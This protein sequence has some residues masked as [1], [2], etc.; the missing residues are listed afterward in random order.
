MSGVFLASWQ[1]PR[2]T[3]GRDGEVCRDLLRHRMGSHQQFEWTPSS[4]CLGQRVVVNRDRWLW[5]SFDGQLHNR[6]VMVERLRLNHGISDAELVAALYLRYDSEFAAFLEG[7]FALALGDFPRGRVILARDVM[8]VCPLH[9]CILPQGVVVSSLKKAVL[10]GRGDAPGPSLLIQSN[11]LH[12]DD[13]IGSDLWREVTSLNPGQQLDYDSR[14]CRRWRFWDFRVDQVGLRPDHGAYVEEFRDQLWRAVKRRALESTSILVSGGVDSS[15]IWSAVQAQHLTD[16]EGLTFQ[17]PPEDP[18]SEESFVLELENQFHKPITRMSIADHLGG[19]VTAFSEVWY[20]EQP[21]VDGMGVMMAAALES[22]HSKGHHTVIT[23][24]WGDQ[25]FSPIASP[26]LSRSLVHVRPWLRAFLAER[27]QHLISVDGD[28]GLPVFNHDL[29]RQLYGEIRSRYHLDC[30][31]A[32][33]KIAASHGLHITYPFLDRDLVQFLFSLPMSVA[34][35]MLPGKAIL[36]QAGLGW[37]PERIRKRQDKGES[38]G[39]I[40]RGVLQD[41]DEIWKW[42]GNTC[43]AEELGLL[44]HGTWKS[45]QRAWQQAAE[46]PLLLPTDNSLAWAVL[47]TVAME[48]WCRVFASSQKGWLAWQST[49]STA[50]HLNPIS[51]SA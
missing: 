7:D 47:D 28:S 14:R 48:M 23:G 8:G 40:N 21:M 18:A 38:T 46:H 32:Q 20:G 37:L 41:Q 11:A 35:R 49:A 39:P 13:A 42:M 2:T 4:A 19:F 30:I 51:H 44:V 16:V 29:Q 3:W 25:I 10:A 26:W 15:S 34:S 36:R 6:Q 33:N 27:S 43:L 12:R 22:I 24:H 1:I 17:L 31:E 9:Y 50:Q 5:V 45:I